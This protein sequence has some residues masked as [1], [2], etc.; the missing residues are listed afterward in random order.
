MRLR[1]YGLGCSNLACIGSSFIPP[2][3]CWYW[4]TADG[5]KSCDETIRNFGLVSAAILALPL[6]AWRSW[7]AERQAKIAQHS[8]LNE[9]YQKG[10]EMLGS[11][12]L[13]VRLGGVYALER[14]AAE[15]PEIYH[16]QIMQLFCVFVR[17][18]SAAE[19]LPGIDFDIDA[20]M[21]AISAR[22]YEQR[23]LEENNGYQ[24][25]LSDADFRGLNLYNMDLSGISFTR[26]D[27]SNALLV[28]TD[29]SNSTFFET[30][31]SRTKLSSADLSGAA[32]LNADLSFIQ[33]YMQ[34]PFQERVYP[35]QIWPKPICAAQ[36][37][38][39]Q[40]L[41]GKSCRRYLS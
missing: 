23:N 37:S 25:N 24:L 7:V 32:L 11:K 6:A 38:N 18:Q 27:F 4:P 8:L 10:A 15:H 40:T 35:M 13:S 30:K 1:L 5:L 41:Q 21:R 20:V 12:V 31:L 9:R 22:N 17:D 14:L 26:V 33:D 36:I 3:V 28:K 2:L 29:F 19:K 16:I 39:K 34:P